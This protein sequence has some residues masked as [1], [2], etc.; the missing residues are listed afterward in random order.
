MAA[1][2]HK[3]IQVARRYAKA[4]FDLALEKK[5]LEAVEKDVYA[6]LKL[7]EESADLRTAIASPLFSADRLRA[8]IEAIL[9]KMGAAPVMAKFGALLA[10]RKRLS[11]LPSV[12]ALFLQNLAEHRNEQAAEVTSAVALTKSQEEAIA[13]RLGKQLN[14]TISINKKVDPSI[15]GGLIIRVGS[16]MFDDSV[17]GKI[18]RMRLLSKETL[19]NN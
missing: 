6:L 9:A 1:I 5:A 13:S 17:R 16:R 15:K 3:D 18:E 7:L 10:R 12:L 2:P 8:M 4:L 19:A 11:V 14:K